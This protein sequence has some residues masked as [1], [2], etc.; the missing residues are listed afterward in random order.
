VA[1]SKWARRGLYISALAAAGWLLAR[2]LHSVGRKAH[3]VSA[4]R[5]KRLLERAALLIRLPSCPDAP[6]QV[7]PDGSGLRCRVTGLIYPYRN[8]VLDLLEPGVARTF[9]QRVLDTALTS[10]GYDSFRSWLTYVLN[11]LPFA[12][13]VAFLQKR[14]QIRGGDVVLDVACGHGNFTVEWAQWAG[15]SG[16]V[17]GLDVSEIM[18][19]R[20]AYHCE[21]WGLENVL[22]IRADAQRMPLA[23]ASFYKVNCSGGFHQIPDL[24]QA[25][26]EIAR[27]SAEN[28]V[29]TASTFAE[30][31][32]DPFKLTKRWVYRWFALHFVPLVWLGERLSALGFSGYE[33]KLT[34][35][36]FAY[37]SARKKKPDEFGDG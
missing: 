37:L 20:A 19:T 6:P 36:R 23:D 14:Q 3:G 25:L 5:R 17:I 27:V 35:G 28:A 10:W 24:P 21:S 12:E 33:W 4:E 11:T 34:G 22:L 2:H 15:S 1:G 18:L 32:E 7:L 16:L 9:N 29:L 8:G 26:R 30:A 13:E 31:P